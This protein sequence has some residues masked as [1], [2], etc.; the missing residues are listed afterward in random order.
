MLIVFIT[1]NPELAI[2]MTDQESKTTPYYTLAVGG[3]SCDHC[4]AMVDTTVRSVAG[5]TDARVDLEGASV[6]V[7]GGKTH[8]VIEALK[9]A[10]MRHGQGYLPATCELRSGRRGCRTISKNRWTEFVSG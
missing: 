3:M 6:E 2:P 1:Q 4:E 9:D 5:V 7:F 10:G 8:E